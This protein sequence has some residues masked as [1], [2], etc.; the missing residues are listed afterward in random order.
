MAKAE[1]SRR[2]PQGD[3]K[4]LYGRAAGRCGFEACRALCIERPTSEGDPS[5]MTGQIAH[6]AAKSDGGPRA[7][8]EMSHE[9]RDSYANWVLLCGRHHP[10]VDRQWRKYDLATLYRW[11]LEHEA[12]VT[13]QLES[14]ALVASF[15]EL[16]ILMSAI[17]SFVPAGGIDTSPLAAPDID[18]KLIANSLTESTRKRVSIGL[19][20]SPSVSD[21]VRR[22]AEIDSHYPSRLTD[23]FKSKFN[24]YWTE[25]LRGDALFQNLC[26][27]ASAGS[28]DFEAQAAGVGVVTHLFALCELFDEPAT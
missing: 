5:A 4:L 15:A 12:W 6:I 27:F 16:A 1:A 10:L 8:P 28:T 7:R 14:A 11:K 19:V 20:F 18:A 9:E 25:G 22:Q 3:V 13:A 17:V 23:G 26:T 2:Y 21:Y 24:E